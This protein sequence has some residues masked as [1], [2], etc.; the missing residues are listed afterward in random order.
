MNF[1]NNFYP[2]F[3]EHESIFTVYGVFFPAMTGIFAGINMA[4]DLKN[5]E[6]SVSVGSKLKLLI[7]Y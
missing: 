3:T 4:S 1:M 7:F 2:N 6:Y 5:P